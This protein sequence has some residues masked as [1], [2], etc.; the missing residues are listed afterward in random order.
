M[1]RTLKKATINPPKYSIKAQNILFNLFVDE[2]NN[3]RPHEALANRTPA[4]I[5]VQSR[6]EYP[7][8]I[9]VITYPNDFEVRKVRVN[10]CIKFNGNSIYIFKFLYGKSVGITKIND[11]HWDVSYSF[12]K[13][14]MLNEKKRVLLDVSRETKGVTYVPGCTAKPSINGGFYTE[15]HSVIGLDTVLE[16]C[17]FVYQI[18]IKMRNFPNAKSN[19]R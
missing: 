5:Y 6:Q 2:F 11:N 16:I 18:T 15:F 14:G 12:L 3:I 4:S 8:R 10:D 9:P 19:S 1:H 7:S 13:F 17:Y